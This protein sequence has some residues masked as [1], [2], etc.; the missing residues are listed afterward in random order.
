MVVGMLVVGALVLAGCGSSDDDSSDSG[1]SSTPAAAATTADTGSTAAAPAAGDD[2][3]AKVT[4][5]EIQKT[6]DQAMNTDGVKVADIPPLMKSALARASVALTP[7]QL[8]KAFDC[9]QKSVCQLGSGKLTVGIADGFGDNTWRK[10]S[11]MNAILQAMTYPDVGKFIATNAH[12][13]LA[14]FQSDLRNLAAQGAKAVVSYNDFG[15][16]AYSAMT[17]AQKTGMVITTYTG[18]NDGAPQTAITTSVQ[19]NICQAG[20]DMA[21]A[22][23]AELGDNPDVAYFSGT[24]GNPQDLGWSKCAQQDGVKS[25]FKADT[26]WTPAGAQTAASALVSSGKPAKAILYSYSDPVPNIVKVF[27]KAGKPVPTIV[28]WTYSNGSACT[29]KKKPFPFYQT[30]SLNWTARVAMDAAISKANG[31]DAPAQ[32]LYPFPFVKAKE[33]DCDASKPADFPG[34][35][36]LVPADLAGKILGA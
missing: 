21:K 3:T 14:T 36:S 11:K 30:N 7:D 23:K 29:W 20:H 6:L 33:T 28:T 18:P 35:S 25:V 16:A 22:V 12:G 15:P 32:V 9:W 31:G 24:P 27:E 8:N 17:A 10:F 34:P 19:P 4:D 1:S 2:Y 5:E 26:N 13:K